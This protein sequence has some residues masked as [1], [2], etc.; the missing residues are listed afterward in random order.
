MKRRQGA[1]CGIA[2]GTPKSAVD[3]TAKHRAAAPPA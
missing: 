3:E 2:I 1:E